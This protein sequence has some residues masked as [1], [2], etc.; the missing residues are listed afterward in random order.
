[1]ASKW[2]WDFDPPARRIFLTLPDVAQEALNAL[3]EEILGDDPR[4]I[5]DM[6][7]AMDPGGYML[8]LE[9]GGGAGIATLLI[10]VRGTHVQVIQV[11][12]LDA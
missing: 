7:E 1:V 9:F 6:A 5:R 8:P 3:M 11:T 10:V 12:W 2:T 4:G